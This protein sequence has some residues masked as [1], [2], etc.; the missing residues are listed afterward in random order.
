VSR[1][2]VKFDGY[3]LIDVKQAGRKFG[4]LFTNELGGTRR[5][6]AREGRRDRRMR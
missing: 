2:V 3:E 5:G 1:V 6:L 4:D